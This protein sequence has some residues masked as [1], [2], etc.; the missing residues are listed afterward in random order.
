[1]L[2][3]L[4]LETF[5]QHLNSKFSVEREAAAPLELELIEAR[6][7]GS[8][9]RHEQFSLMFRGPLDSPLAQNVY[10]F[11]HQQLGA[12]EVFIVPIGRDQNGLNYEAVF[13]R[14]LN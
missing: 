5:S 13:N 3:D 11:E 14:Q 7:L 1:M 2:E 4:H 6:D 10:S 12:F 8:T 9:P